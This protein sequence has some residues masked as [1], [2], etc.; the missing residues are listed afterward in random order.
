MMCTVLRRA[1]LLTFSALATLVMMPAEAD[2]QPMRFNAMPSRPMPQGSGMMMMQPATSMMRMTTPFNQA[3]SGLAPQNF[4]NT[5]TSPYA[6]NPY[7]GMGM[8]SPYLS[9]SG[10]AMSNPYALNPYG[11][12]AGGSGGGY[13]GGSGG[14]YG[15]GSGSGSGGG[16]SSYGSGYGSGYGGSGELTAPTSGNDT[17]SAEVS[18]LDL[19]GIPREGNRMSW[20]LGLRILPPAVQA[21]ALRKQLEVLVR[22]AAMQVGGGG[23]VNAGTLEAATE[24]T[25]Q[26]RDLLRKGGSAAMAEQTYRDARQFLDRV[27]TALLLIARPRGS[28]SSTAPSP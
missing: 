8:T 11:G 14:G 2:A 6:L 15:G 7:A 1:A 4:L 27:D 26:L 16:G 23:E 25:A 21:E 28:A 20:P 19:F 9:G 5:R 18:P 13:G 3:V 12:A 22:L 10:G 24:A 17:A